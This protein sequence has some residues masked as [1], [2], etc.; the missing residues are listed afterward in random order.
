[1][2]VISDEMF[3]A[4]K[5]IPNEVFGYDALWWL[6]MYEQANNYSDRVHTMD[7]YIQIA[8]HPCFCE[9]IPRAIDRCVTCIARHHTDQ[10]RLKNALARV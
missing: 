8:E 2:A 10:E 6:S 9:Q 3:R 4:M 1:M 5:N 7:V